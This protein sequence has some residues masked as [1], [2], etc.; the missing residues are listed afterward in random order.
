MIRHTDITER[1]IAQLVLRQQQIR[2]V[3]LILNT[4]VTAHK[5]SATNGHE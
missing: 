1:Q 5:K 2:L 4:A 3:T